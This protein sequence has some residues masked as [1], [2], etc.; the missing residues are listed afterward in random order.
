ML[1]RFRLH[2]SNAV[3]INLEP[4]FDKQKSVKYTLYIYLLPPLSLYM[5]FTFLIDLI[6]VEQFKY[7]FRMLIIYIFLL[8]GINELYVVVHSDINEV[9]VTLYM[10]RTQV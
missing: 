8:I 3:T 5:I 6:K 7:K 10:K 2:H 4:R 1:E 9:K